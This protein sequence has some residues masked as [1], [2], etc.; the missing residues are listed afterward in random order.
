MIRIQRRITDNVKEN[1]NDKEKKTEI[2]TESQIGNGRE[3]GREKEKDNVKV[4]AKVKENVTVSANVN[5]NPNSLHRVIMSLVTLTNKRAKMKSQVLLDVQV[6]ESV[7]HSE[8]GEN[9]L[10]VEGTTNRRGGNHLQG[11][12]I[13]LLLR[14]DLFRLDKIYL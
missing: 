9:V 6:I 14:T 10:H 2:K 5:V 11:E 12:E 3:N 13:S 7:G 1:H 8:R 4:N